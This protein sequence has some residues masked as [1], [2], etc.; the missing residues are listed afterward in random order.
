M[1]NKVLSGKWK[2]VMATNI[3]ETLIMIDDVVFVID[4]GCVC[5]I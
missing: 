2:V 3:V 5:E 1:F 4:S